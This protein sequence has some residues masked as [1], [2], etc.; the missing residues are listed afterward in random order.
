MHVKQH[1]TQ[2]STVYNTDGASSVKYNNQ[3][4]SM[5]ERDEPPVDPVAVKRITPFVRPPLEP[6]QVA[7]DYFALLS[8]CFGVLGLM[9]KVCP[10]PYCVYA[11]ATH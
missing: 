3:R 11:R 1:G 10:V 8:L 4:C 6:E 5:E 2:D 7:P 9:A